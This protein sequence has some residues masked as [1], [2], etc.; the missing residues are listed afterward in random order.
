MPQI[1]EKMQAIAT[2]IINK[3]QAFCKDLRMID[4]YRTDEKHFSREGKLSFGTTVQLLLSN[5]Q[6]STQVEIY[7]RMKIND[8]EQVMVSSFCKNRYKIEA[9]LFEDLYKLGVR[10]I[11]E[12]GQDVLAKWHGFRLRA[13]DGT[14]IQ[15]PDTKSIR[16]EFGV[17]K[18]GSKTGVITET[19]MARLLLEEDVLNKTFT[20]AELFPIT[21]SELSATY[22]WLLTPT[23]KGDLTLFDRNF[24]SFMCMY[25]LGESEKHFVIRMS[26]STNVVKAFVASG[27]QD[28]IVT[29]TAG[30]VLNY[31]DITIPKGTTIRVR[32]VRVALCTGEVEVLATSLFDTVAFPPDLFGPLY[33]LRWG[34]ETA[35]DVLKNKFAMMRFLAHK[36]QGIYQEVYATLF[37]YNLHQIIVSA[38][39]DVVNEQVT[40]KKSNLN[41]IKK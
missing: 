13:I 16:K 28:Q 5:M 8:L 10:T 3:T 7:K 14:S 34:V 23:N 30:S 36:A 33:N 12:E 27:R 22:D 38:A 4:R 35:I 21:K 40:E 24:D 41:T 19:P 39:Q 26:L 9:D 17:H 18:N 2:L 25:L 37:N 31:E 32:L 1:K 29:F 11:E 15:L 6:H 20:R